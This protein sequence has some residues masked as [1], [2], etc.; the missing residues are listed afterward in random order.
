M[1]EEIK[2]GK[3]RRVTHTAGGNDKEYKIA[4]VLF[5]KKIFYLVCFR[6]F[7]V[8]GPKKRKMYAYQLRP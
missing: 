7:S 4:F 3:Y 6:Q 5:F 1:K 2:V 8:C